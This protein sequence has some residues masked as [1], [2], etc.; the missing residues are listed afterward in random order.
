MPAVF[1][2]PIKLTLTTSLADIGTVVD[3][4]KVRTVD[5]RI[6]NIGAADANVDVYLVD[7]TN[8]H[9]RAKNFP[10]P[11]NT[12][13]SAPDLEQSFPITAGWKIQLRASAGSTL[14]A[15]M[16]YVEDTN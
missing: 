10:I 16:T 13:N 2:G 5:L 12:S 3:A 14:E 4:T 11:Y 15:S 7:G 1:V 8:N 9:Y 6:C